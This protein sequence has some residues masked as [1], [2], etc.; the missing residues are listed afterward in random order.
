M[1]FDIQ[2]L[3]NDV[4]GI[5][6]TYGIDILGAIIILI[7]GW[8]IAAW[9]QRTVVKALERTRKVDITLR[10]FFA[11][12]ARYFILA[13]TVLA[14]LAQFGIQTASLIAVFGAAGLAIGFAL[15]GTLSD[16][17]AG[18]MLLLFRP[19]KVG[20]YVEVGG[21]SGTV[22]SVTLFA[23]ELCTPDNVQVLS[24]NSKIWGAAV[25]NFSHHSTRRVD[26][27]IG[28]GYGEDIDTAMK[29][30]KNAANEDARVLQDPAPMAAV[31]ELAD[32]SVN[33]TVRVWCQASFYWPLKFDLNK[34]FKE[35]LDRAGI[36]IPFPQTAIHLDP[37]S[38]SALLAMAGK[39]SRTNTGL[40]PSL[41][42]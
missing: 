9:A 25:K 14:V 33:L 3:T 24:P 22:E 7:V 15:Q 41:P 26:F 34:A 40:P 35:R 29:E 5:A 27:T 30:L 20:D 1:T 4:V 16:L 19:F 2:A 36:E 8:I 31:S 39:P 23:T 13:F 11:S 17:A 6:T 12:L 32:S 37:E 42:I 28:I 38:R 10:L 18:V 21:L